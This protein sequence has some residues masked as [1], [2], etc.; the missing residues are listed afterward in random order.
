VPG[1]GA[2]CV[3]THPG[4]DYKRQ[5]QW[6]HQRQ[7]QQQQQHQP[8]LA[9]PF[10]LLA[11]PLAGPVGPPHGRCQRLL[12]RSC[13]R[14]AGWWRRL[15]LLCGGLSRTVRACK[16]HGGSGTA[17]S[18]AG[19][20]RSVPGGCACVGQQAAHHPRCCAGG[21]APCYQGGGSK[22]AA[23]LPACATA[24]CAGTEAAAAACVALPA[25]HGGAQGI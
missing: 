15:A 19:S 3:R 20:S 10:P 12:Q 14:P 13:R 2:G 23:R 8:C 25:A 11:W 21:G 24:V 1:S 9:P 5:H 18:C 16:G 4:L 17:E 22:D 6:G 7:Q